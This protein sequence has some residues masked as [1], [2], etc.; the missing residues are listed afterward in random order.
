MAVAFAV[1]YALIDMLIE[2]HVIEFYIVSLVVE[3]LL[4]WFVIM[5]LAIHLV[6]LPA[7]LLRRNKLMPVQCPSN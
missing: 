5:N 2:N 3:V 6:A 1:A 4:H 7:D